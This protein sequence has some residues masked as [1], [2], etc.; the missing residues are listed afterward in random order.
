MH[1]VHVAL[2]FGELACADDT[3][4]EARF[5]VNGSDHE[6][7]G[8]I[9]RLG[10]D[11]QYAIAHDQGALSSDRQLAIEI[12]GEGGS[13]LLL[14]SLR[15]PRIRVFFGSILK[16]GKRDNAVGVAKRKFPEGKT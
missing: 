9:D 1:P 15:G 13:T 4:R 3:S 8:P 16:S 5:N 12:E 2:L 6:H 10:S 14:P 11:H 7:R